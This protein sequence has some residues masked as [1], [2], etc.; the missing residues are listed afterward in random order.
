MAPQDAIPDST[1]LFLYCVWQWD[2]AEVLATTIYSYIDD[3]GNPV[4]TDSPE[5][6]PDKYLAKVK[7]H[8]QAGSGEKTR[9]KIQTAQQKPQEGVKSFFGWE[10]P[11][12]LSKLKNLSSSE[13]PIL[14]YAGVA[15]IVLLLV[16][17]VSKKSPMIRLLAL[18]LLIV[19]GIGTPV[20]MYTSDGGPM[21]ILKKK[22]LASG[23][24]QQDRLQPSPQ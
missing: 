14:N 8:E 15:A 9:S 19:L 1:D 4:F 20:L 3:Q 22:A 24:A 13:A 16:I 21:D 11:T 18:G 17:Y 10:V 5:T 7:T 6:I 2:G 23:Q 12:F